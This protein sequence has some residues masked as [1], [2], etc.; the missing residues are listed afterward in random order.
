MC[1]LC[2]EFIMNVH[3]TDQTSDDSDT[4]RVGEKQRDRKRTRLER[5]HLCNQIFTHYGLKL[6]DWNG[7]KYIVR[8]RKG[9]SEVVHDLGSLWATAENMLH[10]PID[11][12]DP[13]LLEKVTYSHH[14]R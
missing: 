8:D 13:K 2:G 9:H 5:V 7:R 11:P 12:L 3:W 1:V 14:L 10:R 6:E 4:V